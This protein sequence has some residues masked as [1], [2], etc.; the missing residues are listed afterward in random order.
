MPKIEDILNSGL[1]HLSEMVD[2][3]RDILK[4][5]INDDV[6]LKCGRCYLTCADNGY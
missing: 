1:S 5:V 2:L 4:P 6:C 3:E